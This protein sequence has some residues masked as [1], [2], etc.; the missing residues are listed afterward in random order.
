MFVAKEETEISTQDENR[1][2]RTQVENIRDRT[3]VVVGKRATKCKQ[4]TS[5]MRERS[6]LTLKV[7]K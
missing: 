1:C 6:K 5:H 2:D 7:N 3:H 4:S